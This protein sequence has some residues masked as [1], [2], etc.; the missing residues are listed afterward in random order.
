M[1]PTIAD[2][3]SL[4][5]YVWTQQED[6]SWVSPSA[7]SSNT[8]WLN[9]TCGVSGTLTFDYQISSESGWDYLTIQTKVGEGSWTTLSGYSSGDKSSNSGVI[10][11]SITLEVEA[12]TVVRVGY[13]K[14]SGGDKNDDKIVV[15]NVLIAPSAVTEE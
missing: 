15:S 8:A 4:S 3:G 14:D 2:E 13:C 6:G 9:I 11:G 5:G 1:I 7:F 12:G 10:S